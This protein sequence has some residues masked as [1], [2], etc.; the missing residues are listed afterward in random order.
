M[1]CGYVALRGAQ[2][3]SVEREFL[4]KVLCVTFT[5]ILNNLLAGFLNLRKLILH[6]E[7]ML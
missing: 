1:K 7:P 5:K 2:I 6:C 3:E 4:F